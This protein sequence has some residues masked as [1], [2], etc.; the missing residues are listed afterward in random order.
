MR[1]WRGACLVV[2]ALVAAGVSPA[3]ADA[4]GWS[5]EHASNAMQPDGSLAGISCSSST[6]CV[7]V[8]D[9]VDS[10]NLDAALIERWNGVGWTI[11]PAPNP[12]GTRRLR[13][14]GVSCTSSKACV[15]VG[16]RDV[17][18]GS[19]DAI[20][21]R[22]NGSS[23]TLETMPAGLSELHGVSCSSRNACTAVGGNQAVRWDGASWTTQTF[24]PPPNL[25]P[26][27]AVRMD[28]VS[29]AS[30][31]ACIAVGFYFPN[32]GG[33]IQPVADRWDGT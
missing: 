11:V 12:A 32:G 24:A 30:A 18:T 15:A 2:L 23:W 13:L 6:W 20:A 5:L 8:G 4:A 26:Q 9:Y 21:E 3:M 14:F 29:C 31:T 16:N 28:S 1:S 17:G 22:W 7:A 33:A 25:D 10:S 27:R 19:V